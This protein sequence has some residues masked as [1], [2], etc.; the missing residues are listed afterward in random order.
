MKIGTK[1]RVKT[2][3]KAIDLTDERCVWV[4]D[5]YKTLGKT[6]KV[7]YSAEAC[8]SVYFPDGNEWAYHPD[9]LTIIKKK[10]G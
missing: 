7:T 6:G 10:R 4:P 3:K 2:S 5:M 9:S 8:V 1:V